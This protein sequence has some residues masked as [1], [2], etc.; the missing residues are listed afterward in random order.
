MK[1]GPYLLANNVLLAPMAGATDRPYRQ[2]CKRLGA[3]M[4]VSEMVTSNALLW[5]SAKTLRRTGHDGEGLHSVQIVGADPEQ[6]AAAAR[7][8]VAQGAQIIDINMGCP[9]KKVCN[10]LAGSALLR[11]ETLVVRIL[12]TVVKAVDVPVTLKIRTGWD[13]QHRNGVRIA[14]IAEQCGVQALTVHGRTRACGFR[15]T[16]EYD[17]LAAI[18][19]AVSI[20]VIANGDI[21]SPEKA[22]FVL[23]YTQADAIMIGRAAQGQPWIF[24]EISHYLDTGMR[25]PP[26]GLQEI[27]QLLLEHLENLYSFYGEWQGVR[28][29]RKHIGWYIRG[30]VGG[31]AFRQRINLAEDAAQQA[32]LIKEYFDQLTPAEELAA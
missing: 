25:L 11:D 21:D 5:G 16:A 22:R 14:A 31:G 18:K 13:A 7:Y 8:N 20:P 24:R 10:T 23:D 27:R 15:G 9:A 29:A 26:P 30:Q 1:I 12:E 4:T 17:T 3:G 28:V 19:S 32:A 6:L 2:L